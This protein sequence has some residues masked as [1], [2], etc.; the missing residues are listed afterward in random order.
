MIF[1]GE[2][3]YEDW[4]AIIV[5]EDDMQR[6]DKCHKWIDEGEYASFSALEDSMWC[7]KCDVEGI[8]NPDNRSSRLLC[9]LRSVSA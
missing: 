5:E 2:E 3:Q 9:I 6:C 1:I 4:A 7:Y 8:K